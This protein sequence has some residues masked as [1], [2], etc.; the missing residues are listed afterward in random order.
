MKKVY[1]LLSTDLLLGNEET[2]SKLYVRWDN[3]KVNYITTN[4]D[5]SNVK[6]YVSTKHPQNLTEEE[7]YKVLDCT[8]SSFDNDEIVNY[9]DLFLHFEFIEEIENEEEY[10]L[11]EEWLNF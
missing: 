2:E 5:G 4:L 11:S 10:I 8:L 3:L 7:R 6:K 9:N 1:Q